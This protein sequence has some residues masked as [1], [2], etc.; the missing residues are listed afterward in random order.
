MFVPF[1]T[2]VVDSE[3]QSVGTVSRLVLHPETRQVVA[4]VVQQGVVNR[5]EIVVPI[6]KVTNFTDGV[7]L[8]LRASELASLDRFDGYGLR[9][10]PDRWPMPAGFDLRS[11]F[12][13]AGDGWTAATLPF[14]MTSPSATGTP[15][16]T[17]D[18]APEEPAIAADTPV[19][20]NAGRRIG[21]VEGVEMDPA[22]GR[23]TRIIVR[24]GLLF[25]TETAIPASVVASVT[26]R[27]VLGVGADELKKLEQPGLVGVLGAAH[28]AE[29]RSRDG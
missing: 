1:G 29:E 12:L 24:R 3:G 26:D 19:Y 28:V 23:I 7:H 11:F 21:E 22:S 14:V 2:R 17:V 6:G 4:L 10:M 27:V 9:P 8:A 20:D 13:V 5:R 18:P 16:V 15:A 25:R